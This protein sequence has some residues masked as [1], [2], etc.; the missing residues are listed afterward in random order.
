MIKLPRWYQSED[1]QT[2][3]SAL[4]AGHNKQLIVYATGLGK[5]FTAVTIAQE[6][7]RIL[8]ITHTEDLIEQSA[9]A[10]IENI[11]DE[12]H[13]KYVL[14]NKGLI[15]YLRNR[16]PNSLFGMKEQD[17]AILDRIGLIKEDI[18]NINTNFVV[19]SVQTLHRRLD[20]I[21]TDHFD[22]VVMDEA[23]LSGASTYSKAISH[24]NPDLLLGLTATP[25]RA[26]GVS[27]T[28]LFDPPI[29]VNRDISWGINNGFLCKLDAIK[30]K[31]DNDLTQIKTIGN[32]F[33]QG[34]LGKAINTKE[35]NSKIV[36]KYKEY[37]YDRKFIAFAIDIDHAIALNQAF[38]QEGINTTFIVSNE[39]LCPDRRERIADFKAGDYQGLINVNILTAGFDDPSI[40]CVIM[41][42]PTKSLTL[43]LQSIGRGTRIK[44]S[45]RDCIILD[46]VDVTGRH[47]LV[48]TWTL[49]DGVVLE[50]RIFLSDEKKAELI[51]KRD[52]N[53]KKLDKEIDRD[54]RIDIMQLP[55]Q[56]FYDTE[57]NRGEATIAQI[58]LLEKLGFD[59]KNQA[60]TKGQ[61]NE[62]ISSQEI[63]QEKINKLR[64]WGFD[65]SKGCTLGQYQKAEAIMVQ[66]GKFR[67]I[68]NSENK[69][70]L[71]FKNL[72]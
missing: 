10:I 38:H 41:A 60:W 8:W 21:P 36:E 47:N 43:Y 28:N 39:E 3:F 71:P 50:D 54:Q 7:K 42:R 11:L 23:H 34:Q 14:N 13:A 52:A 20:R 49:E 5:T 16:K 33:N 25:F 48:N 40:E 69:I 2:V 24:F 57:A 18:F 61:C 44:P 68:M 35:R 72:R 55:E 32:D 58:T 59:M 45:A 27:L 26:D 70:V 30:V 64:E 67:K 65:T 62:V 51:E 6:F 56:R 29:R 66:K 4:E 37:A 19:A 17:K 46:I 31:T 53:K 22:L 1:I 12:D 63:S 9:M 15:Q